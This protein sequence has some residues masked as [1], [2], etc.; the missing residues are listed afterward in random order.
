MSALFLSEPIVSEEDDDDQVLEAT[1][2]A[3]DENN[4]GLLTRLEFETG[5]L[6]LYQRASGVNQTIEFGSMQD[7]DQDQKYIDLKNKLFCG[8][9]S[10]SIDLT[11]FKEMAGQVPRIKGQRL[12]W[13]KSLNLN[14]WFAARLRLGELFDQLSGIRAMEESS[15]KKVIKEF[16]DELE[17]LVIESWKRLQ[18]ENKITRGKVEMIMDKFSGEVGYFG[19]T[20]MFYEGLET[21]TGMPDPLIL[22]GLFRENMMGPDSEQKRISPNHKIVNSNKLEYAR[23]LG[24][25][26]EFAEGNESFGIQYPNYLKE[27]AEGKQRGVKGPTE[28]ELKDLKP[29]FQ[30]LQK[31]YKS[32]CEQTNGVIPGDIGY[33]QKSLEI[34]LRA[35]SGEQLESFLLSFETKLK[36]ANLDAASLVQVD[37]NL[38]D[39]YPMDHTLTVFWPVVCEASAQFE[40]W[41]D[42]YTTKCS[43]C[44]ILNRASYIYCFDAKLDTEGRLDNLQQLLMGFS[45]SQ[46][47]QICDGL[48]APAQSS[49]AGLIDLIMKEA[50]ESSKPGKSQISF[51]QGRKRFSLRELMEVKE[52]AEAELRVEEALQAYQYTGPL[53]QASRKQL[54][55]VC[56]FHI[57]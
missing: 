32:V 45:D 37:P 57:E 7:Q 27:V 4:N 55:C 9:F 50:H 2:R 8:D 20:G 35:D 13:V 36:E 23:V 24:H 34:G 6:K 15:I 3:L 53:Y 42:T 33:A 29:E 25:P 28:N 17:A 26:K 31:F 49:K 56:V 41:A 22:K 1:F 48:C 16:G 51:M 54:I 10:D 40:K 46:L 14:G 30:K 52:V 43:A 47:L 19:D 38:G 44:K 21:Q 18:A 12:Q 5:F 11:R 39:S